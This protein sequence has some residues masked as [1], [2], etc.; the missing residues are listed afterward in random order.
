VV[1]IQFASHL[2]FWRI[3]LF[4]F[5]KLSL[6]PHLP[7]FPVHSRV[8][9]SWLS[10][11]YMS[12][13]PTTWALYPLH[14][15]SIH[16]FSERSLPC[17]HYRLFA[18]VFQ[19]SIFRQIAL[20]SILSLY[21]DASWVSQ[22]QEPDSLSFFN[23]HS[24]PTWFLQSVALNSLHKPN[25]FKVCI[26]SQAGCPGFQTPA[27]LLGICIQLFNSCLWDFPGVQWLRLHAFTIGV[28]SSIPGWETKIPHAT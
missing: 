19:I 8:C 27:C 13:P 26:S 11:H 5:L 3:I 14:E 21:L 6:A 28:M 9:T 4:S 16:Y 18:D 20:P 22:T 23:L 12:S 15:L 7:P 2:P 1:P 24:L 25:D 17:F 10:T